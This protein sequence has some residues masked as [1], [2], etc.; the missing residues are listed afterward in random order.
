MNTILKNICFLLLFV[1]CK[2]GIAQKQDGVKLYSERQVNF[3]YLNGAYTNQLLQDDFG[4]GAYPAGRAFAA[5]E[6][7][8]Y[9]ITFNKGEKV[10]KTGAAVQLKIQPAKQYTLEY[11]IKYDANFQD[12]LHGKQ[13]GFVVGVGY[14]GGRGEEARTNGNGGSVRLQFDAHDS[15]ISNQLYVYHA[16]M[17]GKYGENPGNQKFF[18]KKGDWNTIRMT[19]TMQSSSNVADGKIDVWCNGKK[20]FRWIVCY[21]CGKKLPIE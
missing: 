5:I 10:N 20:K 12:G 17:K 19:V 16:D 15:T 1:H 6:N 4:N 8:V 9:K 2:T 13:F 21:L 3:N 14:D 11:R 7:G 18:F